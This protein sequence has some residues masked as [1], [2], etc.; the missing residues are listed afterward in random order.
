[1]HIDKSQD[2]LDLC[3]PASP[4]WLGSALQPPAEIGVT[5]RIGLSREAHR[6]WRFYERGNP[7]VSGPKSLLL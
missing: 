1:M 7:F 2:G 4:L 3:S 5:T 6:Q